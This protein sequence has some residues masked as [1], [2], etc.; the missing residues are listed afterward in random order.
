M[1]EETSTWGEYG[2]LVLKELEDLNRNYEKI[3]TRI[4]ELKTEIHAVKN[5]ESVVSTHTAWIKE[6]TEVWSPTQMKSAK[7]ELY[8]QK[9][10]W[11]A[12]IA[13]I[14]FVQMLMGTV[15]AV[16]GNIK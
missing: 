6:V 9:S 10:R 12:A 3:E 15:L 8:K 13:I 5:I 2:K 7:D 1:S 11:V 4:G 14:T 16:W